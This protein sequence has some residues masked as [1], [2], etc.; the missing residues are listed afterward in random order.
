M[1]FTPEYNSGTIQILP[2]G[3][4]TMIELKNMTTL[5]NDTST[6]VSSSITHYLSLLSDAAVLF[7][8]SIIVLTPNGNFW[9][10]PILHS[11][12]DLFKKYSTRRE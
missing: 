3:V 2:V 7:F 9:I 10:V 5:S 4:N 1:R 11:P 6:L 12:S 8:N